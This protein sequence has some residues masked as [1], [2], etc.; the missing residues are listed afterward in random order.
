MKYK[1][2]IF[3]II[4]LIV[5]CGGNESNE[6]NKKSENNKLR[7]NQL[8]ISVLW[9]LSDRIDETKNSN[10]PSNAERD[11]EILK[12]LSEYMKNDMRNRGSFMSKG[13]IKIFFS[14]N[15]DNDQ[16]NLIAKKLDVNLA[17]KDVT[18]KKNIYDNITS[19]FESAAKSIV[20]IT[21]K[22]SQWEGSDIYRFFKNDVL[23]YC[24]SKDT[25]YRNILV[26]VT[27]GYIYH[28]N[29]IQEINN[30][31]EFLLPKILDGYKLRNNPNFKSKI[32]KN[33]Y[34]FITTRNDLNNLEILVLEINSEKNHKDDE[35]IIKSYLEKWF[36]EMKVK[37]YS[38]YNTDIP[39]NTKKR[40]E[41]FL[42]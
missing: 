40:I 27:D 1:I 26:V 15:P 42:N 12:F 36:T 2:L 23:D 29:S 9:D 38:I 18:A 28:K 32:E 39:I 41:N 33:D 22:T 31:S 7:N 13:K 10:T 5:S 14:P 20:D 25:S 21:Q 24:V 30:R 37:K 35:D 17:E 11:V 8:N 34:G 3:P 4:F 16:I 19:D 6:K